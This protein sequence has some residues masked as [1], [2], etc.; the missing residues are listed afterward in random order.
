MPALPS[1]PQPWDGRC[2]I[3][4][5]GVI[6]SD[7]TCHISGP[8][9]SHIAIRFSSIVIA[10]YHA[11]ALPNA[12]DCTLTT[13]DHSLACRILHASL[14]LHA[15]SSTLQPLQALPV[16]LST[17]DTLLVRPASFWSHFPPRLPCTPTGNGS[18]REIRGGGAEGAG[19]SHGSE[20]KCCALSCTGLRVETEG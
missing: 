2:S 9:A 1:Y 3:H 17:L 11:H 4:I 12:C 16:F 15:P 6:T 5:I 20:T 13:R 7:R 19:A 18:G 8:I 14:F 10:C